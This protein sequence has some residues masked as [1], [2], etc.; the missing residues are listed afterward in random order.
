MRRRT[1]I[2]TLAAVATTWLS[3]TAPCTA[4][5]TASPVVGKVEAELLPGLPP[6]DTSRAYFAGKRYWY[7]LKFRPSPE[8]YSLL[9]MGEFK[10]D[11]TANSRTFGERIFFQQKVDAAALSWTGNRF[12]FRFAEKPYA[13]YSCPADASPARTPG[14]S[15]WQATWCAVR[16]R[17]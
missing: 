3:V 14:A 9:A 2:V 5:P 17:S 1:W 13:K 4:Q 12:T 10:T 7:W 15:S 11:R 16:P 6:S 8:N